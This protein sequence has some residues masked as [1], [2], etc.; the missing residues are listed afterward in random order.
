MQIKLNNSDLTLLLP[1][2]FDEVENGVELYDE[3]YHERNA[4][5]I[6]MFQN[7]APYSYGNIVISHIS[8]ED[9]MPFGD[10][11]A[12][13]DQIH[14]SLTDHQGLIEVESGT[15]PRGFEYI[16]SII[17]TYHQDF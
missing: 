17:K 14:N 5:D 8:Q 1:K 7:F 13:I 9:A 16:Y 10:D 4:S 2:H 15:N 6:L 11:K 12:L 3:M